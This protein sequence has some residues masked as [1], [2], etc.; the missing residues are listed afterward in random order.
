MGY[1]PTLHVKQRVIFRVTIL[2]LIID[3]SEMAIHCV[4]QEPQ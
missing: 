4:D 1:S 2:A 3:I